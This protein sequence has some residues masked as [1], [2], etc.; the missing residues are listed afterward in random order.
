MAPPAL[1]ESVKAKL[2]RG[3]FEELVD[4]GGGDSPVGGAE[5]VFD[6]VNGGGR[7]AAIGEDVV[8][9]AGEGFDGTVDGSGAVA[10]DA[11]PLGAIF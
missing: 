2:T 4:V 9:P 1:N 11:L 7:G 6:S 8:D 5:R 10:G 3:L